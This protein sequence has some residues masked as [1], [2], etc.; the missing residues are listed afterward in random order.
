MALDEP[1]ETDEVFDIDGFTYIVD[2]IFMNEAK[3]VKVDF[4]DYGFKLTSSIKFD[5]ACGGC[6]SD[7]SCSV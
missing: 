4:I 3:P 5:N 2:K 7:T 6:G 1:R